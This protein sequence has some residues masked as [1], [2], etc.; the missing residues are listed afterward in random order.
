M[1]RTHLYAFGL[2][3]L[4][5]L[6]VGI[7][8][9]GSKFLLSSFPVLFILTGRFFLAAVLLLPLH[10]CTNEKVIPLKQHFQRLNAKD[11]LLLFLQAICAGVFFNLLMVLGLGYTDAQSAGIITSTLPALIAVASWIFLRERFTLKKTICVG[12]ATLGLVIIST[13]HAASEP[14]H[15]GS[16]LGNLL[17][18]L[19]LLPET[20]YYVLVKIPTKRLPIFLMSGIINA[21]NAIILFPFLILEVHWCSFHFTTL[22]LAVLV[23]V[24]LSS[25]MFYLFW[26][27]G[28]EKVDAIMASLVTTVM[29]ISTVLIAWLVLNETLSTYY[30]AGMILAILSIVAYAV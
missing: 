7:N 22:N 14:K 28:S 25:G 15:T 9:T 1:K 4:A 6:S 13:H 26:Y 23:L 2:L 21:I 3:A 11:W 8:I 20:A 17:V 10:W 24:G 30:L 12:F 18:F 27:L 16:L 29:P 5:Q 19:A